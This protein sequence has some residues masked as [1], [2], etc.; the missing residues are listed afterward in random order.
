M[1]LSAKRLSGALLLLA[2]SFPAF[3]VFETRDSR[4]GEDTLI[5]DSNTGLEWLRM[6]VSRGM[7]YNDIYLSLDTTFAGFELASSSSVGSMIRSLGIPDT[8]SPAAYIPQ[9]PEFLTSALSFMDMLGAF[10][11]HGDGFSYNLLSGYTN[12]GPPALFDVN[13]DLLPGSG[14]GV[15]EPWQV[16]AWENNTRVDSYDDYVFW[17]PT[18]YQHTGAWLVTAPVPEPSTYALMALGMGALVL[19]IRKR[20]QQATE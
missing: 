11:V 7:S 15:V 5:F 2:C 17:K 13:G 6:D 8:N 20:R 9:T 18:A 19:C 16:R 14:G 10:E 3:A 1:V 12:F 4:F